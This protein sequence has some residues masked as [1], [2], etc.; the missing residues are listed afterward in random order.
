MET[1]F[2]NKP[3]KEAPWLGHYGNVPFHLDY[4]DCSIADLLLNARGNSLHY[5]IWESFSAIIP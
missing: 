4:P 2:I 3:E 1:N 5:P